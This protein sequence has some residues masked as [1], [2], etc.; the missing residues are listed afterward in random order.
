MAG[1]PQPA[2]PVATGP[3][4]V[5]LPLNRV[6]IPLAALLQVSWL[7]A[8]SQSCCRAVHSA[9]VLGEELAQSVR[10]RQAGSRAGFQQ[11]S[12]F[13]GSGSRSFEALRASLPGA[14]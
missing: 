3:W 11:T 14:V 7:G 4:E 10:S 9:G 6:F 8:A 5:G 2:E 1:S 13:Q 12:H